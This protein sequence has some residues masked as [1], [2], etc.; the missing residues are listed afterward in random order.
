MRLPV[1]GGSVEVWRNLRPDRSADW[2]V[3]VRHPSADEGVSMI[4]SGNDR[5]MA[6]RI[7]REAR[8]SLESR[9]TVEAPAQ[10]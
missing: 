6:E 10:P 8:D 3:V 7:A 5:R 4:H 1:D 2:G 9:G